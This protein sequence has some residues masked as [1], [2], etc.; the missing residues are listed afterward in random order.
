MA[1]PA[2]VDTEIKCLDSLF[3]KRLLDKYTEQFL[4]DV[5]ELDY[6]SIDVRTAIKTVRDFYQSKGT[7]FSISYLFKLL[8]GENI[9]VS[10]PKDQIIKPSA[11]TWSIDTVLRAT[12][13]SGDPRNIRDGVLT[14]DP[15][16]ADPNIQAAQALVENYIA[17]NT[18]TFTIYELVLS[19]E[20]IS[21]T[22]TAPYKTKLAEPLLQ[23]ILLLQL[24]LRWLGQKETDNFK[25]EIPKSF[26][27][28]KSL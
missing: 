19:E 9:S 25:L 11:S 3:I 28:K 16:I 12:L 13:V 6:K 24:T 17:I 1:M 10:Y 14:Q 5:P 8:Y 26:N 21:G 4:P 2:E 15:D 23:R 20:T 18:S 22:F 27:T 7:S